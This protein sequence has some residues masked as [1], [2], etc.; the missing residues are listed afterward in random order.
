[1]ARPLD[2]QLSVIANRHGLRYT[3]YA[4]D[5][6]FSTDSRA[7]SRP[8]ALAL[9]HAVCDVMRERGF[10]PNQAKTRI[11]PPRARKIVLGLL[12]DTDRPRLTR[13]FKEQLLLHLYCL[14]HPNIGPVRHAQARKFDSV[15]GMQHHVF[16]LAAFAMGIE[17]EWGSARMEEL[18]RIA[19]P[20]A[21]EHFPP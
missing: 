13:E 3:R 20:T 1:V 16:G 14:M 17:S 15:L 21:S 7:F 8:A 9:V 10:W 11:I 12:V 18:R 6:T 5:L 19:W 2:E 4:D